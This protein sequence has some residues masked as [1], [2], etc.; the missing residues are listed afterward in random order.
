MVRLLRRQLVAALLGLSVAS[1][2]AITKHK[3][4]ADHSH[5]AAVNAAA[6]ED[7]Q[8]V[9]EAAEKGAQAPDG[10][11]QA[12][13]LSA[14]A[15]SADSTQKKEEATDEEEDS[16]DDEGDDEEGEE[17]STG[18][19]GSVVPIEKNPGEKKTLHVTYG[20]NDG[21]LRGESLTP[22][23]SLTKA[24]Q[25]MQDN[26]YQQTK[27][28]SLIWQMQNETTFQ[29]QVDEEAKALAS[30]TQAQA[31]AT[32]LGGMR[33]EM[34]KFASPFFL[35]H[36]YSERQRLKEEEKELQ[37][38]L[39]TAEGGMGGGHQGWPHPGDKVVVAE[40]VYRRPASLR[41]SDEEDSE[42][43]DMKVSIPKDTS[44][45]QTKTQPKGQPEKSAAT[46]AASHA[47][48]LLMVAAGLASRSLL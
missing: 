41:G 10:E 33:K 17:K 28:N 3:H 9:I 16:D 12:T 37:V 42:V 39:E 38:Q 32:M 23:G 27:I 25:R 44:L 43:K 14:T 30:E 18:A 15:A 19:P 31:L 40:S 8:A 47:G 5:E 20:V 34:R 2:A 11:A 45:A 26:L 6:D 21:V 36:L 4:A 35:E 22:Q 1:G 13:Q 24:R 29:G 48:A 46:T 7:A